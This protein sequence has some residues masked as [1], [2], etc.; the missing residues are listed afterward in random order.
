MRGLDIYRPMAYNLIYDT[1]SINSVEKQK[2]L[3]PG[4]TCRGVGCGCHDDQQMGA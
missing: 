3:Q 2:R 4:A 1:S